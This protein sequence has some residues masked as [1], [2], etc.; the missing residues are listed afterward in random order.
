MPATY[1][2]KEWREQRGETPPVIAHGTPSSAFLGRSVGHLVRRSI[3]P[4]GL[5]HG[6]LTHSGGASLYDLLVIA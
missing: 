4:Y 2:L 5:E 1:G 6:R 3:W